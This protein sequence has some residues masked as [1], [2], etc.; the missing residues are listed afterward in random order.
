ML[1]NVNQF[2]RYSCGIYFFLNPPVRCALV[3]STPY[4][5]KIYKIL[6]Y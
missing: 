4:Y 2:A 5:L 1:I 6:L 3:R